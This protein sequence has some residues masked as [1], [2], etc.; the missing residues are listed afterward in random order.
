MKPLHGK[1]KF[2][3][4]SS[5][6]NSEDEYAVMLEI[7]KSGKR[8]YISLRIWGKKDDWDD[9]QERFIIKKRLRT[10]EEK[11]AN[12]DRKLK[13]DF[14][15]KK[16]LRVKEI[17][18]QFERERKDWTINQFKTE[19][20]G[21]KEHRNVAEYFKKHI[22]I[23]NQ[24]GN[25]GNSRTYSETMHMIDLF[26]KKFSNR[27]FSEIDLSYVK[28]FD[29]FLQKR[30]LK[31][32]SRSHY[33]RTLRA[34]LN[35]AIQDKESS[36]DTYPFGR[37]AFQIGAIE[38]RTAKR[39]LPTEQLNILKNSQSI[40]PNREYARLVF[41]FSYHCYGINVVDMAR[42]KME[43]IVKLEKGDYIIYKREKT[44]TKKS[45]KLLS[46]YIKPEIQ[47]L[48]NQ[49][50]AFKKPLGDYLLPIVT[51][52]HDN[53]NLLYNHIVNRR[54]RI[55]KDL[56]ELGKDL[57]FEL[58]LTS[59]VSRHTMSMQ[60]RNNGI[61]VDKIS[62]ILGHQDVQTTQIYLDDLDM[63]VI[64]EAGQVL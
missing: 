13:N 59:Y 32:N 12:E 44:K 43:N 40:I 38:T 55:V 34:L 57:G 15:E 54:K 26:D 19:F 63:S 17:L 3:M 42:L 56:R 24:T 10:A 5:S 46:I 47:D 51:V 53:D 11:K 21:K 14:I 45:S 9:E 37:G 36:R 29:I 2:K 27:V 30:N 6:P 41:L 33:L 39:Y 60:L 18:S 22:D 4:R 35:K 20:V 7:S 64:D 58:N 1:Y 49:L 16:N 50:R 28:S 48:I 23:L 52:L 8:G 31:G 62:Q 61:T 25:A